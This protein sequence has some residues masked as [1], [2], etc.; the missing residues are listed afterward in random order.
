VITMPVVYTKRW[1]Q[2]K[3][4]YNSLGHHADVFDIPEAKELMRKGFIWAAK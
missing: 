4:F 2:G 1:G 3:V